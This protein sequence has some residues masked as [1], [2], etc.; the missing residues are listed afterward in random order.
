M[1][2]QLQPN[3][4]TDQPAAG[5]N[6]VAMGSKPAQPSGPVNRVTPV[7]MG[8]RP[9]QSQD[10]D[11]QQSIWGGQQQQGSQDSSGN[12]PYDPNSYGSVTE[13]DNNASRAVLSD[14]DRNMTPQFDT[15]NRALDN[16]LVNRGIAVGSEAW[17]R[18]RSDLALQQNNARLGA[19]N[20]ATL[21]GHQVAGDVISR[22]QSLR[23]TAYNEALTTHNQQ[24]T[25]FTN[26]LN[27]E[28]TL[29][30]QII[31]E[32][33]RVRNS[34]INDASIYLSGAPAIAMPSGAN[35]ANY[36]T[37]ATDVAGITQQGYAN[38]M[39]QW[40]QRQAQT[41]SMWQGIGSLAGTA[42]M[43]SSKDFKEDVGEADAFLKRV[44]KVHVRTWRYDAESAQKFGADRDRHIGPFAEEWSAL[45][46]GPSDR[47]HLG[48]A[49]FTLYKA[50]QELTAKVERMEKAHA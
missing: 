9:Q 2:S 29:R 50:F 15:Q 17:N 28:Q 46:G 23:G 20:Q 32:N 48:D 19:Q 49:I 11:Q 1:G 24:N 4:Q 25:D 31:G 47:I 5:A 13:F 26:R 14:F 42:V 40:N 16:D 3:Q 12:L 30:G 21:T 43:M 38:Q 8:S 45:F 37:Q 34:A 35:N 41:A 22:E 39:Q 18:A 44:Q 10:S 27:M 36:N 7:A 33:E 6:M